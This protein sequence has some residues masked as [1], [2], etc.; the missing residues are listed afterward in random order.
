MQLFTLPSYDIQLLPNIALNTN[1]F[2]ISIWGL[3]IHP[4]A[5]E[6]SVLLFQIHT[7]V[8]HLFN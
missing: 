6:S 2:P 7:L 3:G 8:V 4:I 5:N 1:P